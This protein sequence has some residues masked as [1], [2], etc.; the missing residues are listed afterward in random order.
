MSQYLVVTSNDKTFMINLI[1][2]L[3]KQSVNKDH[4]TVVRVSDMDPYEELDLR[5]AQ[6]EGMTIRI[7]DTEA[8][9]KDL[10]D[11]LEALKEEVEYQEDEHIRDY[12]YKPF[13][14]A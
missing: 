14:S 4:N 1:D 6:I 2:W 11:E 7:N 5:L 13:S 10:E 9:V 8:R 3:S 12:Q